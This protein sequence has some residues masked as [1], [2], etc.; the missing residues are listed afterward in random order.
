[1]SVIYRRLSI[2]RRY[3]AVESKLTYWNQKLVTS[4]AFFAACTAA[5]RQAVGC[6]T[7]PGKPG[8]WQFPHAPPPVLGIDGYLTDG[9]AGPVLSLLGAE[10]AAWM[11]Y[12]QLN[13]VFPIYLEP[14]P[15]SEL[16]LLFSAVDSVCALGKRPSR[17]HPLRS[18]V[19]SP[20]RQKFCPIYYI[21]YAQVCGCCCLSGCD[22]TATGC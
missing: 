8:A 17:S 20:Q 21:L 14:P 1:M 9:D 11:M 3:E 22:R 4:A 10:L 7:P 2:P 13:S 5:F 12:S 15:R 16:C 6:E 19:E 18:A